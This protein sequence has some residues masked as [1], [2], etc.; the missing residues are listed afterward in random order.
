V[1]L[2]TSGRAGAAAEWLSGV[3]ALLNPTRETMVGDAGV[4]QALE[5][6]PLYVGELLE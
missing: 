6:R 5:L 1:S 4:L 2:G 3:Q